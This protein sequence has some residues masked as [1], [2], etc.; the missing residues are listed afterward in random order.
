MIKALFKFQKNRIQ[1]VSAFV[2]GV[3]IVLI[4][5]SVIIPLSANHS[6]TNI[7]AK[8]RVHNDISEQKGRYI[9]DI[10]RHLG[11]GGFIHNFKNYVLRQDSTV[12]DEIVSN[13]SFIDSA[14]TQLEV[15][16]NKQAGPD[17]ERNLEAV[18]NIRDTMES[19]RHNLEIADEALKQNWPP[20]ITDGLVWVD[21]SSAILA[22]WTLRETWRIEEQEAKEEFESLV[23]EAT[24]KL[25]LMLFFVPFLIVAGIAIVWFVR[26]L[27]TEITQR[28]MLQEEL[29][30]AELLMDSIAHLGQG[31][32][33][34][35]KD[36]N[37]AACNENFFDLLEFPHE[38]DVPGTS[39]AAFFR[40][41]AERGEYGP[42][43]T[44]ELINERMELAFQFQPHLFERERPDGTVIEVHGNPLPNGGIVTTYTDISARKKAE[45][46][47][48][49]KE[50]Q[51]RTALDNMT[52]GI[53]AIDKNLNFILYNDRYAEYINVPPELLD[54]GKPLLSIIKHLA[55]R[56]DYGEG[57]LETLV[58]DRVDEILSPEIVESELRINNGHCILEIR[59]A[60]MAD[61][62]AV[63]IVSDV[64]ER[65]RAR[66]EIE[67][68][69]A[70]LSTA[71]ES[72][73]A[74][75]MLIDADQKLRLFNDAASILY[76]FPRNVIHEG[77]SLEALIRIRAERGDFGDGDPIELMEQ[78]L[79][80]Y[81]VNEISK[82]ED[83]VSGGR[84]LD[85]IRAP[86]P[87]GNT[88]IVFHDITVRMQTE[89]RLR[90]NEEQLTQNIIDLV[91]SQD[92]LEKQSR[93]L[94]ELAE[95][96]AEEKEKA[97]ASEKS[98][99]EFLAS[100]SHEI[101]TPMTGVLG[102]AD[103]LLESELPTVHKDTVHKI[104]GAG[105]SL[106]TI[107][108]DILDLSK[109]EAGKLE[110]ENIDF[111]FISVLNDAVELVKPK[112]E[113]QG[114]YL[115]IDTLKTIPQFL[116]GDPTRI[117]QVL[118]NLVGN[119]VKFTHEGGITVRARHENTDAGNF[120]IRI[121]VVDTGIG[122]S[123]GAQDKLFM[124]FTQADASTS[125]RYEGTGLGLSISKRL[126]RL[127]GGGIGVESEMGEG[128]T[129]W[130]T[131]TAD[132]ATAEVVSGAAQTG[133][134]TTIARRGV[135]ML[136]AEDNE[137]NQLILRSVLEPLGHDLTFA[138]SGVE[139]VN[140]V[141]ADDY[142]LILMDV[143]MPEMNGP[144]ATRTIR[145][146]GEKY[147]SLPIIAVT[148]DV[149]EEHIAGYFE[150]GMNGFATKPIDREALLSTINEVLGEE[151]HITE[152]II[153]D[154][155]SI[156]TKPS[157]ANP[158]DTDDDEPEVSGEVANF[159]NSLEIMS[160]D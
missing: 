67:I 7:A 19:Y 70:Q 13:L 120:L 157:H 111:D 71:L 106:L 28:Q 127:M 148:A 90:E 59:K 146:M 49:D 74:G 44:D 82:Y 142:E 126:T 92:Y 52:D 138:A 27:T 69:E 152:L 18:N 55:A 86:T 150:A 87:D 32:S 160:T 151:I 5:A 20:D 91:E 48:A 134:Y 159:L 24:A 45:D 58:S 122:I 102:L 98:K 25:K 60:P 6:I 105:Q 95:M 155:E 33:V 103:I 118:I 83:T 3:L 39:L 84:T 119:A 147:E 17:A 34:F 88:V 10:Y 128:S 104:K 136:I 154:V 81:E 41:N 116:K 79:K 42:G 23:A 64:T 21:D 11:Y 121:E 72:M 63:A 47:L 137:L 123:N 4:A 65:R 75:I 57:D 117:R 109:M 96:Y 1:Y 78:R 43:N 2:I 94:A 36:L 131:F 133:A 143:R 37:L 46:A 15:I 112:A 50:R 68:K 100:M 144:D 14:L 40:H 51:L 139:A 89:E 108:N 153:S 141:K 125:R 35:D 113:E 130:F 16:F 124:D 73:S 61:G 132:E 99:S 93:E 135:K 85:V 31:V 53:F 101:R 107:I 12:R 77:V 149:M 62:G 29:H 56:G 129:F 140:A 156:K 80:Q 110:I 145:Q 158:N 66:R 26:R 8:W 22:I 38:L 30:R 9:S 97:Q 76:R 54:V 115:S 114:L